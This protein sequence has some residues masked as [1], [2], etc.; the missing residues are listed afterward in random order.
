MDTSTKDKIQ[1]IFDPLKW[2]LP[3]DT[4][5]QLGKRLKNFWER[6]HLVFRTKTCDNSYYGQALVIV[7]ATFL[8]FNNHLFS[9]CFVDLFFML[10]PNL[11]FISIYLSKNYVYV[12]G[13]NFKLYNKAGRNDDQ[14]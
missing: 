2:G 1:N 7:S 12:R 6:F 14:G 3:L 8:M 13:C 11:S 9:E 5:N 10:L 4:M